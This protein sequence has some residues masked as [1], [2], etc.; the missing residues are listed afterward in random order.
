MNATPVNITLGTAGHIDHGKT[1][2]VKLLTGCE[3]DRL[4]E[5]IERGMSIELGFAPCLIAGMEVGI[6]DVPG[7][8]HFIKTMV[9]GATGMDGVL[10][11][12]AADDGIMPQTR[13]H[14]DILTLLGIS[15]GFVAMTKID[16]VGPERIEEVRHDIERLTRGTFLEGSPIQP[17][18]NITGD[19]FDPFIKALQA[20]V[21]SIQP[22]PAGGVFRLPVERAF[23]VK[24]YG[25]V[26]TGIPV[27]GTVRLGDEIVL[28]PE[29]LTGRVSGLQ[30]YGHDAETAMAGQCA[31]V[32]IRHWE[33]AGVARGSVLT[34]PGFFTPEMW[35]A[36]R[37]RLL[38]HPECALKNAA[39]VKFHV[40]T[41]EVPGTVYLME[42]DRAAPGTEALVQVRL[43]RPVVAGPCD[44]F[45]LRLQSPPMTIGGGMVIET[46]PGRLRRTHP[47]VLA[48]L[49]DRAEAVREDS[50]FV[51]YCLKTAEAVTATEA[52][53]A[54]RAK[55]LPAR[56]REILKVLAADGRAIP[57]P[58]LGYI[59]RVQAEQSERR[60][61]EAMAAFHKASPESPGLS[62]DE[63]LAATGLAKPLAEAIVARLTAA[64]KVAT[65][66][67]RLAVASHRPAVAD[68]DQRAI[69]QVERAFLDR[70]FSPPSPEEVAAVTG[71]A[72]ARAA[73]AVR[74]L[75][76]QQKLVQVAPGML[77]HR[78]A[79]A[80]A[81]QIITDYI[82]KEGQMESVKLKYL[83]DT[84]RKFA[85]PLVD[86]FDRVGLTRAV[87]HTRY[88]RPQKP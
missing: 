35:M 50:T 54:R 43:D 24:G 77:F 55:V 3:T 63:L 29:N 32:N 71:V 49:R 26:I 69:D 72:P 28:L 48:D 13:E 53:L 56:L 44:R 85:I 82:R 51:D 58:V 31:A 64:G 57:L 67:G 47:E 1:A 78:D 21:K 60:I 76:E 59:H 8:E 80:R 30:V 74:L 2:L 62:L 41:S 38:E 33:A 14:L 22:K 65:R 36:C 7:H 61:L 5:E 9:A 11:V 27:A 18:S 23:S 34:L 40:G 39:K 46:T 10:L 17:I 52:D 83:L 20:L 86:Y 37:L 42:G 16:R 88:L 66:S 25:T 84:T 87:G 81:R 73:K 75:T 6:V 45:I 12:I 79:L 68:E 70:L 15:H 19:G 4:K